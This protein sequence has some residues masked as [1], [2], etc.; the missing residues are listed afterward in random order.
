MDQQHWLQL[1]VHRK[2]ESEAHPCLMDHDLHFNQM[3]RS[4]AYTLLY[5]KLYS[6]R[7]RLCSYLVVRNGWGWGEWHREWSLRDEKVPKCLPKRLS[8]LNR[9][10]GKKKI[11]SQMMSRPCMQLHT[12]WW[13]SVYKKKRNTVQGVELLQRL[14]TARCLSGKASLEDQRQVDCKREHLAHQT[15]ALSMERGRHLN[16]MLAAEGSWQPRI[17]SRK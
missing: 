2:T 10:E 12:A 8:C 7:S 4:F 15:Q 17:N 3:P 14:S 6:R 5:E 13:P 9:L 11:C 16:Q 1:G